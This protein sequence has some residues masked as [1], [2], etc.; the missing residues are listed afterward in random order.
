LNYSL[1]GTPAASSQ[2]G[3]ALPVIDP[4]PVLK[5]A[6]GA[7]SRRVITQGGATSSDGV[8]QDCTN[9][10]GKLRQTRVAA[11]RAPHKGAGFAPRRQAGA[12]KRLA[13]IYIPEPGNQP[14][15]HESAFERCLAAEEYVS[16]IGRRQ[17]GAEWFDAQA[18]RER[19]GGR[20]ARQIHNSEP[21]RI[22][23][24]DART[25][26]EAEDDMI[27]DIIAGARPGLLVN[28]TQNHL[29]A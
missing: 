21:T 13:H 4:K 20:I 5:S 26:I 12:E 6:Q 23:I 9:G 18:L 8:G 3:F 22:G 10:T 29:I 19:M 28:L 16:E 14:L 2:T 11:P 1:N 15:V 25:V 17:F 24:N 27:M 7:V